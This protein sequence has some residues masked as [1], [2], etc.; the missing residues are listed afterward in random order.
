M[1]QQQQQQGSYQGSS[2]RQ[3]RPRRHSVTIGMLNEH[4]QQQQAAAYAAALAA[5]QGG[6]G[7]AGMPGPPA[8]C[9]AAGM[10]MLGQLP[11]AQQQPQGA[12]SP[13]KQQL[14]AL[15][16]VQAMA[17]AAQ[18]GMGASSLLANIALQQPEQLQQQLAASSAMAMG[19]G[20]YADLGAQFNMSA[21]RMPNAGSCR[22]HSWAP[23]GVNGSTAYAQALLLQ[24]QQ[25]QLA[26]AAA[27]RDPRGLM[28]VNG[29]NG[30]N[31]L[32]GMNVLNG[33]NGLG[34]KQK[35]V[36][37]PRPPAGY[38]NGN[39]YLNGHSPAANG[40]SSGGY[41][42]LSAAAAAAA[43]I[44]QL[45][46]LQSVGALTG[47]DSISEQ[48]L[49]RLLQLQQQAGLAG[50]QPVMDP[51]MEAVLEAG[52]ALAQPTP[53]LVSSLAPLAGAGLPAVAAGLL[54]SAAAATTALTQL[55]FDADGL[56]PAAAAA[57]A[58]MYTPLQIDGVTLDSQLLVAPFADNWDVM[59]A[60]GQAGVTP[61]QLAAVAAG[62]APG[63]AGFGVM[64][65]R[66]TGSALSGQAAA[67]AHGRHQKALPARSGSCGSNSSN[68]SNG[69]A[70]STSGPPSS[71]PLS[72][73]RS[74]AAATASNGSSAA[75]ALAAASMA[76]AVPPIANVC[77]D[78]P[79][80]LK[81]AAE[82]DAK[83]L[84]AQH[85]RVHTL[86]AALEKS[87]TLAN[88]RAAQAAACGDGDACSDA[89]ADSKRASERAQPVLF[90]YQLPDTGADAW[91]GSSSS[92]A[93]ETAPGCG[94]ISQ[95]PS[96]KL[97]VGN[98]GWWV[99]EDDLLHWF[100]RFGKVVHVKVRPA[101]LVA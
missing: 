39:G 19:L 4:Q 43:A 26:A 74:S 45:T 14:Q 67:G 65:P 68:V 95:E 22:R 40:S 17:A 83:V 34:L 49:T 44:A 72:H 99:T 20:E 27:M 56:S 47:L 62:L 98:I 88:V 18:L 36:G 63:H 42:G 41:A 70:A 77:S 91:G 16:N 1:M 94:C 82:E 33:L 23:T 71:V 87:Q 11:H 48:Q 76:S 90:G 5:A 21:P 78:A 8:S 2:S 92:S 38:T 69:H 61:Q 35:G 54:P 15:S 57:A 6:M 73:G 7:A 60:Q 84:A 55:G 79:W 28:G 51:Y 64:S 30:M 58:S 12:G 52:Q 85:G 46:S 25:R 100:S 59:C 29:V 101:E 24:Q 37:A 13:S 10:G 89:V 32:N 86:V 80:D 9:S 53:S 81:K 66:T 3:G 93:L 31:S 96:N 75:A 97:F 50:P